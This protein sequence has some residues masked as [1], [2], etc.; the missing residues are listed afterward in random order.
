[1][2]SNA[3]TVLFRQ[4]VGGDMVAA[5][6]LLALTM[7]ANAAIEFCLGP[8]LGRITDAIGR[9]ALFLGARGLLCCAASAAAACR[10]PYVACH[11][12]PAAACCLPPPVACHLA[13]HRA[14][15]MMHRMALMHRHAAVVCFQPR[16]C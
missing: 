15:I 1:M 10:L 13:A 16:A 9:R 14:T 6:R 5:D 4:L 12:P 8:T 7:S 3:E 11:L 2:P